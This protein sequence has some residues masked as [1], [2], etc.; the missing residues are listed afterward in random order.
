MGFLGT[1]VGVAFI[2]GPKI[3]EL[4][5][6]AYGLPAVGLFNAGLQ[7]IGVG[8][9]LFALPETL[10]AVDPPIVADADRPGVSTRSSVTVPQLSLETSFPTVLLDDDYS[11]RFLIGKRHLVMHGP[12]AV[13]IAFALLWTT[14]YT[15]I[16]TAFELSSGKWFG[17]G[18]SEVSWAWVILG[19]T[20]VLAQGGMLGTL[21]RWVGDAHTSA[22]GALLGLMGF[23]MMATGW[24]PVWLFAGVAFVGLG[25]GLAFGA[26]TGLL[27][28]LASPERQGLILG[29]GQTAQHIGRGLGPVL[30][31][32]LFAQLGASAPFIAAG[33][34]SL[35]CALGMVALV[36]CYNLQAPKGVSR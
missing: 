11:G 1:A 15:H 28:R 14:G 3:G 30:G 32:K 18:A 9:T 25:A 29:L 36:R 6:S 4:F 19:V 2:F 22:L 26:S 5:S 12:I 33:G 17:F 7:V 34:F 10:P 31:A 16:N 24:S 23:A 27:S 8:I 20:G 13:V 35:A 21:V